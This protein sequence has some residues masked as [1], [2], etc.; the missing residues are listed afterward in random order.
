MI[1]DLLP[2]LLDQFEVSRR[3]VKTGGHKDFDTG[4]RLDLTNASQQDGSD[5]LRGYRT[6]VVRADESCM[7]LRMTL[8]R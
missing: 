2:I 6:S 4:I 5:D 1:Y 8:A 7:S 3:A